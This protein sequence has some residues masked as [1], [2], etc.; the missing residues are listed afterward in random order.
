MDR[1]TI[2]LAQPIRL[3]LSGLVTLPCF[4]C[5]SESESEVDGK[6]ERRVKEGRVRYRRSSIQCPSLSIFCK[7]GGR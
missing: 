1:S 5:K 2:G 6:V 4:T 7:H 3:Y